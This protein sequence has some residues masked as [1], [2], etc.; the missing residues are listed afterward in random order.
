MYIDRYIHTYMGNPHRRHHPGPGRPPQR[1]LTRYARK[2]HLFVM[3]AVRSWLAR[4]V[5]EIGIEGPLGPGRWFR[6]QMGR[7]GRVDKPWLIRGR[8]LERG[9]WVCVPASGGAVV[10]CAVLWCAVGGGGGSPGWR[11]G[12]AEWRPPSPAVGLQLINPRWSRTSNHLGQYMS[13]AWDMEQPLLLPSA[14][15]DI[16]CQDSGKPDHQHQSVSTST[17]H[18]NNNNNNNNSGETG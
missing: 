2:I 9:L 11:P 6:R 14:F 3:A 10:Y 4:S 5:G 17:P 15:F 18:N 1:K 16:A 13:A 12:V 7:W 8:D